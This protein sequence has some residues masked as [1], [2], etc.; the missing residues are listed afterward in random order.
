MIAEFSIMPVGKGES[1]SQ[2]IAE[3]IK[4][5]KETGVS[6]Q[7]GPMGTSIEGEWDE[8]MGII[9]KCRDKLL[10]TSN[11]VYLVIKIDDRK[12]VTDQIIQKIKSVESKLGESPEKA[13]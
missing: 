8:V 12:G 11:R 9:K 7:L 3:A 4:I 5:I 2:D 1:L 13:S 10:E 6:Y